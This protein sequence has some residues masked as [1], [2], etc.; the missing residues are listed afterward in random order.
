MDA[1]NVL[2][3]GKGT[4]VGLPTP[5]APEPVRARERPRSLK[6]AAIYAF[7]AALALTTALLCLLGPLRGLGPLRDVIPQGAMFAVICVV[8]VVADLVPVALH[9]RGDTY[10]FALEEVP[11]VIGLVFLS[12]NLLVLATVC[13][14]A[15]TFTVLRRQAVVKLVFNVTSVSLSTAIAAV[16]FRELLGT[17]A[18]SASSAGAPRR[19]R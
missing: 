1:A 7:C 13:A 8:W 6:S 10:A 9:Y 19:P 4:P 5:H 14:V 15:F 17:T 16:V 18:R 12:P 2:D 11:L 3:D